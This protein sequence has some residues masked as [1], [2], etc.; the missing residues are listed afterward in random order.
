[1]TAPEVRLLQK[2]RADLAGSMYDAYAA[3]RARYRPDPVGFAQ[4]CIDWPSGESLAPYQ[5]E[6]LEGVYTYRRYTVRAPHGAGK[7]TT[8]ALLILHFALTTDMDYDW[9][10]PITASA[11]RQLTKFLLPELHKWARRLRWERIGREPFD[12]RRELLE[13]SLKLN[14]GEA[15]A[16]ASDQPE[17]LE[18]AHASRLLY[19]F[20]EAKAIP[21]ETWNATEGAFASG[22]V[23]ALAISTPGNTIGQFYRLHTGAEKGWKPRHVTKDEA[24]AAGRM[25]Q[26]W[27]DLMREK[28]EKNRPDEWHNRVLGEFYTSAPDALIPVHWLDESY[29]RYEFLERAQQIERNRDANVSYGVDVAE[30]GG[31]QFVITRLASMILTQQWI[32]EKLDIMQGVGHTVAAVGPVKETPIAVDTNGVGAGVWARL[33]ELGYARVQRVMMAAQA[34]M[35][36]RHGVNQFVNMR[37]Y[38]WWLLREALDPDNAPEFLLALPPGANALTEELTTPKWTRR[39]NGMIEIEQKAVLKERLGRSPDRAESLALAIFAARNRP[40]RG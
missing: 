13:Q 5:A 8:S 22:D 29:R 38:V 16:L 32:Y 2:L 36:D 35:R 34:P 30:M 9:K 18:G 7:S 12:L 27:V 10:I 11:W 33:R 17:L 15:F 23:Y 14:T 24:L 26:E 21:D 40:P 3:F 31:D 1:M 25:T 4:D 39:S 37:S 20:D 19:V 28:W 6:V